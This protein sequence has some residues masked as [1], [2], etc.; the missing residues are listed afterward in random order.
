MG[1]LHETERNY[2]NVLNTI[3]NTFK[4]TLSKQPKVRVRLFFFS[5]PHALCTMDWQALLLVLQPH[6]CTLAHQK[7]ISRGDIGVIFGN[8]HELLD[9]HNALLRDLD[10]MMQKQDGRVVGTIFLEHVRFR[11]G[12]FALFR[13]AVVVVFFGGGACTAAQPCQSLSSKECGTHCHCCLAL[14]VMHALRC[15]F[16]A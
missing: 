5:P 15:R 16:H 1:E 13:G 8:V 3:A 7:V 4:P 2:V 10:A 11:L 14:T 12:L 9:A 6:T